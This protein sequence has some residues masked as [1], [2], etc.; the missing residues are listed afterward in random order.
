MFFNSQVRSKYLFFFH[1]LS[2]L[3]CGQPVHHSRYFCKFCFFVVDY[4][5]V[6]LFGNDLGIRLHVEIPLEFTIII[7]IIIIII[8]SLEFFTSAFAD[9]FSLESEW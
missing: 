1:I 4:Y 3:L 2:I 6:W 7:I 9:G 8:Y 5:K